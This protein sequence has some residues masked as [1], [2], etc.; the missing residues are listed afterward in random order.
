R[1]GMTYEPVSLLTVDRTVPVSVCVAVISAPGKTAP[2]ASLTVPLICAVACAQALTQP[3]KEISS[4]VAEYFARHFIDYSPMVHLFEIS[5][6]SLYRWG[7][8]DQLLVGARI[9]Y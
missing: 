8:S 2:L 9:V 5:G 7:D 4:A 1:V 6:A 3:R